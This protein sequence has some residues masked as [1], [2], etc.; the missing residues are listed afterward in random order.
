[1]VAGPLGRLYYDRLD[2]LAAETTCRRRPANRDLKA[3]LGRTTNPAAHRL[4]GRVHGERVR[5]VT[6][7]EDGHLAGLDVAT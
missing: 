3:H 4:H 5:R 6:N 7:D 2:D 1:V